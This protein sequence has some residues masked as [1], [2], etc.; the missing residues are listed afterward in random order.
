[1]TT[2]WHRSTG[3]GAPIALLH[4]GFSDSRDFDT[5]LA[6]LSDAYRVHVYDRRGH[7][8]S[9]DLPGPITMDALTSDAASFLTSIVGGPAVLCGYSAGATVALYTALHRPD[10]V[11]ALV[12]ISAA[13]S[14][15]GLLFA[16]SAD[17]PLPEPVVARYAEVSPDG[18]DH[19]PVVQSKVAAAIARDPGLALSDLSKITCPTLIVTADDDLVTLPH[20]AS[21][22]AGLPNA[23]LA[24]LPDTSHLLLLEAPDQVTALVRDFLVR[25]STGTF[26]TPLMP[27]RRAARP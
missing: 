3:S 23:R 25:L 15:D 14:I 27:I 19:L 21:L 2:F 18:R 1:M 16:P 13:Y 12:L 22:L 26:R 9:P 10:L 24:V 8:R 7:G 6:T 11:R 17:A 4:G 20:T 5:S